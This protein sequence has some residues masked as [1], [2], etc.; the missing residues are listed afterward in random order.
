MKALQFDAAAMMHEAQEKHSIR[1]SVLVA[2]TGLWANP[3]VHRRLAA[4]DSV[5][6][7]F[8]K[9]RRYKA[10]A[11]ERRAEVR[12]GIRLDDNTYANNAL[13]RSLGLARGAAVGFE[14]CHIWPQSC[15]DHRCHTVIA[16]LVLLP[17]PLASLTDH[18]ADVRAALQ[19]RAFELYKWHPEEAA[20]PTR[21]MHYPT[22]W[23]D[24]LP[25]TDL[26]ARSIA[27]RRPSHLNVII[28]AIEVDD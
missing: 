14:V 17:R 19:Y 5:G 11:G 24:P 28:E 20:A 27:A 7:F 10:G 18:D 3:E 9:T 2:E 12:E 1:L 8:P 23:R 6:A 15:Y 26:I 22:N 21:P 25:F 4:E 16:N 13:K